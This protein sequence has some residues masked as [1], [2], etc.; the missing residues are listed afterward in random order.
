MKEKCGDLRK[1]SVNSKQVKDEKWD[2]PKAGINV[3]LKQLKKDFS[4]LRQF[5]QKK[6]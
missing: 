4:Q 1:K 2:L 5:V 6:N 3:I